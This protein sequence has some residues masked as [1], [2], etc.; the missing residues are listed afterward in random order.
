[1]SSSTV[2]TLPYFGKGSQR[3]RVAEQTDLGEGLTQADPIAGGRRL[4]SQEPAALACCK[5]DPS[6]IPNKSDS[7]EKKIFFLVPNFPIKRF[8]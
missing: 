5:Q 8:R 6:A 7:Q 1:M 2:N 4:G 3:A